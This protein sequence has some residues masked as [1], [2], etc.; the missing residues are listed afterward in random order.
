M[1]YTPKIVTLINNNDDDHSWS[2]NGSGAAL[3][4]KWGMTNTSIPF[5]YTSCFFSVFLLWVIKSP[6]NI[7]YWW[8]IAPIYGDLGDGLMV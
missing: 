7:G 1:W 6:I 8:F 5:H 2:V 3:D 4:M